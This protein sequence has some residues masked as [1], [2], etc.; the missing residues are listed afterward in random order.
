VQTGYFRRYPDPRNYSNIFDIY[1]NGRFLRRVG[2]TAPA[3]GAVQRANP[4]TSADAA[5]LQQ[6]LAEYNRLV[7]IQNAQAARGTATLAAGSPNTIGGYGGTNPVVA[8]GPIY[9]GAPGTIGGDFSSPGRFLPGLTV[10]VGGARS[11]G[12]DIAAMTGANWP[13][14]FLQPNCAGS[15]NGCR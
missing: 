11:T 4:Q 8:T 1:Q 12:Q 15:Y 3:G 5:R 6:L 9:A 2:A 13:S 14:P 7:A 10:N